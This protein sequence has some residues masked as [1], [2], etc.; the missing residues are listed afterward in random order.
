M[1]NKYRV[2][3]SLPNH[4]QLKFCE[5]ETIQFPQIFRNAVVDMAKS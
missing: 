3:P 4:A 2:P 1:F 5:S